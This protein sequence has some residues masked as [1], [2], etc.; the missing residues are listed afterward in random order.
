MSYF[1]AGSVD[2]FFFFFFL[3]WAKKDSAIMGVLA[4]ETM[5]LVV[6]VADAV[7]P[8]RCVGRASPRK[9]TGGDGLV[10]PTENQSEFRHTEQEGSLDGIVPLLASTTRG[11]Y[12]EHAEEDAAVEQRV[13]VE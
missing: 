2:F 13:V 11:M 3:L 12:L 4:M 6:V 10:R 8:R 9:I 7:E 5:G 1:K